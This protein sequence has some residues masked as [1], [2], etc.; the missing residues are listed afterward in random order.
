MYLLLGR[1]TPNNE[2][3]RNRKLTG[4]LHDFRISYM[5]IQN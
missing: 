5:I 3:I 4:N 2:P 1:D